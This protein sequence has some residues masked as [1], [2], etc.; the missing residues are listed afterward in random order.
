MKHVNGSL[1]FPI[2]SPSQ[3]GLFFSDWPSLSCGILIAF[4]ESPL[5]F[6]AA[7]PIITHHASVFYS[8]SLTASLPYLLYNTFIK[9][10][11]KVFIHPFAP[12]H[13]FY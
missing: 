8:A 12:F 4:F 1:L 9:L 6:F 13:I 11:V 2:V 10:L 5:H 3:K 7:P